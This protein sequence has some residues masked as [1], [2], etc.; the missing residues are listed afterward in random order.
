MPLTER[1]LK[2]LKPKEK[3]YIVTDGRG[4]Y[5]EVLATGGM[6][7]RCRYQLDGKTEKITLGKYPALTLKNARVKRDEVLSAAALGQSP[8]RQKQ[9][10][11]VAAA[12]ATT[13]AEFVGKFLEEVQEKDR[14]NN[15]QVRRYFDRD[16]IPRI[17]GRPMKDITAEDVRSVIWRKKDRGHDAAAG[18]LRG[19]LKKLCDYGVTC[20]LLSFNPVSALP[21]RHVCRTKS[22][23]RVLAPNEIRIFLDAVYK[24]DARRQFKVAL[25]LILLT[26][27]RKS[28]LLLARW[29]DVHLDKSEWHIPAANSKTGR[30]HVVYLSRQAVAL[31]QEL[32]T[33]AGGSEL[34]LPGRCS[35]ARPIAHS[36]LNDVLR[37]SLQGQDIPA[38]TIHDLRRTGATT[39]HENGWASDVVEKA[40]NHTIGGV[41]GVYNRAEYSSQR[42]EML[43]FWA[44]YI[45]D[46]TCTNTV[47]VGHFG[48]TA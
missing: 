27:V 48:K 21:M 14:K 18:V 1:G 28:E 39:L 43:Q 44:D 8:A 19:L 37:K 33:L 29:D 41:R 35:L 4:L 16:V 46:L 17:G 5:I 26:M 30:P 11:K 42:K 32:E 47:I 36:T 24:S 40:L 13:V 2:A 12:D 38:F 25:H 31:F 45:E 7:W 15:K 34:V 10:K 23:D 3:T 9:L 6:V 20:G 22:R